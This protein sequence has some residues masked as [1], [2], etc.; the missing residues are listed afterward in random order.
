LV[1]AYFS[2]SPAAPVLRVIPSAGLA[3]FPELQV[4]WTLPGLCGVGVVYKGE[5]ENF[6]YATGVSGK[7]VGK[8]GAG[9]KG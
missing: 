5:I 1:N 2:Q 8:S 3:R 7:Q 4:L 9:M 6:N